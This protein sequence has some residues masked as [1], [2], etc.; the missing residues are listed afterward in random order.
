M[1][2]EMLILP[3][4]VKSDSEVIPLESVLLRKEGGGDSGAPVWLGS[5]WQKQY[6]KSSRW[7]VPRSCP[8]PDFLMFSVEIFPSWG[9][10]GILNTEYLSHCKANTS[11]PSKSLLKH[12]TSIS[13][14][15]LVWYNQQRVYFSVPARNFGLS[16]I[17]LGS[18][19]SEYSRSNIQIERAVGRLQSVWRARDVQT[20]RLLRAPAV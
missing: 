3:A 14:F 10:G 12:S 8:Y 13:L 15:W 9:V 6:L 5:L 7:N 4:N 11:D 1:H 16:I 19:T 18:R 20:C 2:R 17:V